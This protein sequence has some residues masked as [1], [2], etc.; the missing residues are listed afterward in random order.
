[1]SYWCVGGAV[2][3]LLAIELKTI[4]PASSRVSL[5]TFGQ[6]R[7]LS[8]S[9]A[10]VAGQLDMYY[11]RMVNVDDPIARIP[12]SITGFKHCGTLCLYHVNITLPSYI[13]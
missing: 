6:P 1:M 10:D 12:F 13:T 3:H 2:A 9:F 7:G 11:K 8:T 5:I 4:L